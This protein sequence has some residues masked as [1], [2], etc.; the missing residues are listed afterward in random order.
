MA[1]K[2]Q[3][4]KN[5]TNSVLLNVEKI[6]KFVNQDDIQNVADAINHELGNRKLAKEEIEQLRSIMNVDA[7][8]C[9]KWKNVAD[10]LKYV[11]IF[12]IAENHPETL[13]KI[14]EALLGIVGMVYPIAGTAQG[15]LTKVPTQ[16][17]A[18]LIKMGGLASP[19]YLLYR[20]VKYIADKKQQKVEMQ[21]E[22]DSDVNDEM[23]TLIIVCKN[24]LLSTEMSNLIKLED[25]LD[26]DSIVGTKDGTVH[27]IIWN[28]SAWEAFHDKVS[29]KD[30]VLIIG[31]IKNIRGLTAKEIQFNKYG[32]QYGWHDNIAM[33]EADPKALKGGKE[34][35]QFLAELNKFQVPEK[36]KKNAKFKFG[37]LEAGKMA[38]F[39][40]LLIGDLVREETEVRKQ[41]LIYGIFN[42]YLKDLNDFLEAE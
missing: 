36:L 22:E 10:V 19:E 23:V 3:V 11:S 25:D 13:K 26:E 12:A 20:G 9:A 6:S 29:E 18:A 32:I 42:L 8:E 24:K 35:E 21:E 1:K 17:F 31:K 5:K 37:W 28:E 16:L 40:P 30:K 27:T 7:L 14:T 2:E 41:Q 38:A 4:K 34:Y 39:P 33:I 15:V